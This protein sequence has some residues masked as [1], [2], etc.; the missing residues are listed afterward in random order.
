MAAIALFGAVAYRSLPVADLPT[1]DFPTIQVQAGLP[2]ADPGTMAS[3]VASPLERQFTAISGIDSMISSSSTGASNITLQFSLDRGIDSAAVDV[4]TAIATAMP[5]LPAGLP[6]P[7]TFRKQNP[8]TQPVIF[9]GLTSSTA[10]MSTLDAYAESVIA[11]RISM[12]SGVS[13][14]QVMGAQKFAVRVQVDPDKLRAQGIALNDVDQALQ[15]WNVNLPTGQLFGASQT[16]NVTTSGQLP[17]ADQYK[18]V[19]VKYTNGRPVRL[20]QLAHVIDDVEDNRSVSWFYNGGK[21]NRA[22]SMSV[23][24]QPGTNVIDVVDRVRTVVP[25]IEAQLP[26]SVHLAVRGDRSGPIRAAFQDI[27]WTLAVTLIL[28]VGVIFLFLHNGSA[29]MIPALALPFS[30]LGTFAVMQ[31]LGYSLNNL[32]MMALILSVGFVVDDAIVMLEN[33]VR[34]V[35]HGDNAMDAALKGSREITYTILTM[36]TS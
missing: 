16:F 31:V 35:E 12:I 5:L 25:A 34:R 26:P 2:G 29:T 15:N 20:E 1:V 17:T 33:I 22:I 24:P 3:T 18:S 10:S 14:V 9:L 23:I 32:S 7:P 21:K 8:A 28:V 4:Q 6:T 19:V 36:T 13:Q 11:P 30:I 27:Q